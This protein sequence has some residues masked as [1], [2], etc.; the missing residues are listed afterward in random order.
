MNTLTAQLVLRGFQQA[1]EERFRVDVS[2]CNDLYDSE[3]EVAERI[4]EGKNVTILLGVHKTKKDVAYV[5][6]DGKHVI[7][8]R[9]HTSLK[10][11]GICNE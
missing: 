9:R 10:K 8:L 11:R 5:E 3:V 1:L 7:E 6:Q 2:V 4:V